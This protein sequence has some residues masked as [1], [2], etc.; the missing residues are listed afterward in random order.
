MS[1]T[2]QDE[3]TN[4]RSIA[5]GDPLGGAVHPEGRAVLRGTPVSPG[6]VVAPAFVYGD[7]LDEVELRRIDPSEVDGEVER[8]RDAIVLVKKELLKDAEHVSRELGQD[9]ADVFLVHS[10]ILE[11]KSVL[12]AVLNSIRNDLMNAEAAVAEEM[13]RVSGVLA[14]SSDRYLRDRSFD[15][16]DIGKRVI[17][18]MLGVWAHCPLTQPMILVSRELRAS[19]TATMERGRILGFVTEL[20]GVE[21][22]AAILARSMGVPAMSGVEGILDRVRT[23]DVVA[24]D[25]AGGVAIVDPSAE[26]RE[27]YERM[28]EEE[29]GQRRELVTLLDLPSVTKDGTGIS[30][31]SNVGSRED[32]DEA[33][34]LRSDGIVLLRSELIFMAANLFLDEEAQFEAYRDVVGTM[35]ERPVTIRTFS[36][37]G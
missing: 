13:K 8:L 6:F 23:G 1:D 28:R 26:T 22:H 30:L 18:R 29:K 14:S 2:S 15:V 7:I 24:L 16:S 3:G 19:D 21:S 20:G 17:E 35:G 9:K 5:N 27:R 33:V 34:E 12:E 31:M 37:C 11:D 4:G 25:G 32:A 36:I 10:M